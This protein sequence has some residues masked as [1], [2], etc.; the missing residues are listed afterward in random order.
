MS[1]EQ[2]CD[3]YLGTVSGKVTVDELVQGRYKFTVA[4]GSSIDFSVNGYYLD[5]YDEN[6]NFIAYNSVSGEWGNEN[7]SLNNVTLKAGTY[8]FDYGFDADFGIPS[9]TLDVT[10][11]TLLGDDDYE[12]N[13]DLGVIS[14]SETFHANI[15]VT[16]DEDSYV[17]SIDNPGYVKITLDAYDDDAVFYMHGDFGAVDN[18]YQPDAKSLIFYAP[19]AGEYYINLGGYAGAANNEYAPMGAYDLTISVSDSAPQ[20]DWEDNNTQATAK[21]ITLQKEVYPW[22]ETSYKANLENLTW[23]NGNDQDYF[24][25]TLV[26]TSSVYI[27]IYGEEF[28]G[29]TYLYLEEA[30]GNYWYGTGTDYEGEYRYI[31]KTLDAGTYYI[32]TAGGA[33]DYPGWQYGL[34]INAFTDVEED[35]YESGNDSISSAPEFGFDEYDRLTVEGSLHTADDVDYYKFTVAENEEF[36]YK[37]DW[38]VSNENDWVGRDITDMQGNYVESGNFIVLNTGDYCIRVAG[39]S[40]A[41]GYEVQLQRYAVTDLG[42]ITNEGLTATLEGDGTYQYYKFTLSENGFIKFEQSYWDAYIYDKNGYSVDENRVLSAGDY[43]IGYDG[44]Y[45]NTITIT[46]QTFEDFGTLGKSSTELTLEGVIEGSD[47]YNDYKYNYYSFTLNDDGFITLESLLNTEKYYDQVAIEVISSTGEQYLLSADNQYN[48]SDA[49]R[50]TAGKYFVTVRGYVSQDDPSDE[51]KFKLT[52]A[53]NTPKPD[54]CEGNEG[55]DSED[56]AYNLGNLT[57]K[58][59]IDLDLTLDYREDVDYFKFTLSQDG[60]V[61]LQLTGNESNY[62]ANVYYELWRTGDEGEEE[63]PEDENIWWGEMGEYEG[64]RTSGKYFLKAGEYCVRIEGGYYDDYYNDVVDYGFKATYSATAN[65]DAYEANDTISTAKSIGTISS[66]GGQIRINNL[67]FHYDRDIDHYK[68]TLANDEVIWVQAIGTFPMIYS[69]E[70]YDGEGGF[71]N[72]GEYNR[73]FF[74]FDAG[75]YTIGLADA[76][77]G[78]GYYVSDGYDLIVKTLAY[79]DKTVNGT[80]NTTGIFTTGNV[81]VNAGAKLATEEYAAITVVAENYL[82]GDEYAAEEENSAEPFATVTL[83]NNSSVSN[84]YEGMSYINTAIWAVGGYYDEPDT[85]RIVFDGKNISVNATGDG[86]AAIGATDSDLE[87]VFS[88]NAADSSNVKITANGKASAVAIS[89]QGSEGDRNLT[90]TGSFGGTI[91]S[92]SNFAAYPSCQAIIADNLLVTGDLAGTIVSWADGIIENTGG[93]FFGE[94][95]GIDCSYG[96]GDFTVVGEISGTIAAASNGQITVNDDDDIYY[97]LYVTAIQAGNINAT[98]S[99]TIFAGN[100]NTDMTRETFMAK[101]ANPANAANKKLLQDSSRD[102]YAIDGG[103]SNIEF[104]DTATVWGNI[105]IGGGSTITVSSQAEI[106]G[107]VKFG[108]SYGYGKSVEEVTDT[109]LNKLTFVLDKVANDKTFTISGRIVSGG[110]DENGYFESCVDVITIDATNA[111]GGTYK[112][113][114]GWSW[115]NGSELRIIRGEEEMYLTEENITE[116]GDCVFR[117]EEDMQI[118]I[119]A[120]SGLTLNISDDLKAPEL[121]GELN[122]KASVTDYNAVLSWNANA[123]DDNKVVTGYRVIVYGSEG[124]ELSYEVATASLSLKDLAVGEYSFAVQARDAAGNWSE[125]SYSK[126]EV[127][128][129]TAPVFGDVKAEIDDTNNTVNLYWDAQ[130]NVGVTEYTVDCSRYSDFSEIEYTLTLGYNSIT[131]NDL[132][133]AVT[134]YYRINAKDAAENTSSKTG[135]FKLADDTAPE[136]VCNINAEVKD[137]AANLSWDVATDNVGVTKYIVKYRL[138]DSENWQTKEVS[139]CELT[140]SNLAVGSYEYMV[141]AADAAGNAGEWSDVGLFEI[142]DVTKPVFN[143]TPTAKVEGGNVTISWQPATDNVGIEKYRI[144]YGVKGGEYTDFVE[145]EGSAAVA[146]LTALQD[147]T[148]YIFRVIAIDAAGNETRTAEKT[149]YIADATPPELPEYVLAEISITDNNAYIS[150]QPATDNSGKIAKYIVKYTKDGKEKSIETSDTFIDL[151][152]L[153]NGTYTLE[154]IAVDAAGNKTEY[155]ENSFTIDY[156]APDRFEENDS[157]EDATELTL[158]NGSGEWKNLTIDVDGDVDYYKF[159]IAKYS[160]VIVNVDG[161]RQIVLDESE[162]DVS[163]TDTGKWVPGLAA[164]TYFVKVGEGKRIEDYTLT[165]DTVELVLPT[166]IEPSM[167]TLVDPEDILLSGVIIV[168]E[169]VEGTAAKTFEFEDISGGSV[170]VYSARNQVAYDVIA[171]D[172]NNAS[173]FAKA[174]AT[175]NAAENVADSVLVQAVDDG[176]LD[177]F[178]A[179]ATGKWTSGY[180]ARHVGTLNGWKGT[181]DEVNLNGKNKITDIFQG[182]GDDNILVLSDDVQGDALFVDDIY[183]AT[184]NASFNNQSRL[185]NLK[186][187][188]AGAGNDV[189]D[190]TSDDMA[191]TGGGVTVRGGDGKDVIWAYSGSNKLFGDDG[192]DKIIGAASNDL[193]AGGLG[194]DIL[195]GGGGEDV[196]AFGANDG[197][198]TITQLEGGTITLW[199]AEGTEVTT[200][201]ENKLYTYGNG[202]TIKIDGDVAVTLQIGDFDPTSQFADFNADKEDAFAGKTSTTIFTE[203]A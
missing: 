132:D 89:V 125:A 61:N 17:F 124:E 115:D 134:Y 117:F 189:I 19:E 171:T 156:I 77:P 13:E 26:E 51:F 126:F 180:V 130:D 55:N 29:S 121:T 169:V 182:S 155:P 158:K 64:Y 163:Y 197:E 34:K 1:V 185:E 43:Y 27:S 58:K 149:F 162:K 167:P 190:M 49:T 47:S 109:E 128:D 80:G 28:D 140:L 53:A 127:E 81:T 186:E 71:L 52:Y 67:N 62:N 116:D 65:K 10:Q 78:Y 21:N 157:M 42:T 194:N 18:F 68:F 137:Y 36:V 200:V 23:H 44:Y 111:V 32:R 59:S 179:E 118:T 73:Y 166:A 113:A 133:E 63:Y 84:S 199:F 91:I 203:L 114:E 165:I 102:F 192:D 172:K 69:P 22:G 100:I 33:Y 66:S 184:P 92:E 101:L 11:T 87:L 150:W 174:E 129:V 48:T 20:D 76:F 136:A 46:S 153:A 108:K 5:I 139:G 135:S 201:E 98:I 94:V 56:T 99:G 146:T 4:N 90:I 82:A 147:A 110:D 191:Y 103:T 148:N 74:S 176:M 107:N 131:I 30:N 122:A 38:D 7:F 188:L 105:Y 83:K 170:V 85:A 193:I 96:T 88:E 173:N 178:F 57:L 39:D 2:N 70:L 202:C 198:D 40:P 112:L 45:S 187:I 24:K 6:G 143:S 93:D 9:L 72:M 175:V 75:T 120:N 15:N 8:Y 16:R 195:H 181:G 151:S 31:S 154:I 119:T 104:T 123:F 25:F 3:V 145:V 152:A 160:R 196:F 141:K 37:F 50:L 14:D 12:N 41:A 164:G 159:T 86:V 138:A 168:G 177:L 97:E 142:K 106:F 144:E 79:S 183:S 54:N 95:H 60:Y 35:E 161:V